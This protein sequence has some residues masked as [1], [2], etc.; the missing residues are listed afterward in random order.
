MLTGSYFPDPDVLRLAATDRSRLRS[1]CRAD[2]VFE[3][4]EIY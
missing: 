3:P 1:C 2:L 4:A